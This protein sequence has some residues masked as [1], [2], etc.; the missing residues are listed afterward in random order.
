MVAKMAIVER[1]LRVLDCQHVLF[2]NL[3]RIFGSGNAILFKLSHSGLPLI[4]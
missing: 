1:K 2:G 4:W 3:E